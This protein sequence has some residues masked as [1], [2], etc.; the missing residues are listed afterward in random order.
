MFLASADQERRELGHAAT[1]TGH[2]LL[3]VLKRP[4]PGK[5]LLESCGI[6]YDTAKEAIR[7][8]YS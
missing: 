2:V 6:E 3:A 5:D 8:L 4:G 1:Q 7:N